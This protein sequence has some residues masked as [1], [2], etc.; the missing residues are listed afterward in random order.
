MIMTKAKDLG[1]FWNPKHAT[2]VA[3]R[4]K[5]RRRRKAQRENPELRILR[6]A[7]KHI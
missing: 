3:P 4:K 6:E 1:G 7:K 5:K 2:T